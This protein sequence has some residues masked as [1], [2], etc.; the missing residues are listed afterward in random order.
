MPEPARIV[1]EFDQSGKLVIDRSITDLNRLSA[2]ISQV[3]AKGSSIGNA[4]LRAMEQDVNRVAG[5]W[6]DRFTTAIHGAGNQLVRISDLSMNL[7][8]RSLYVL[9]GATAAT[10]GS[11]RT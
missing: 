4:G 9:A 2:A 5:I 11:A 8:R 3:A 7:A 1:V 10:R 6:R